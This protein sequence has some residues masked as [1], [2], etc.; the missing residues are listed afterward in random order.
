MSIVCHQPDEEEE[1][2]KEK[3]AEDEDNDKVGSWYSNPGTGT[4]GSGAV[5]GGGGVGKYLK[6]RSAL[7]ESATVDAGSTE[8][9][10]PKKRKLASAGEFKDFS[11]W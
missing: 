2:T 5:G 10:V 1:E 11:A 4:A 6:A 7:P 8:P 9:A 3:E